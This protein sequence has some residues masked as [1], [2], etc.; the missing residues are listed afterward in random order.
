MA[1]FNVGETNLSVQEGEYLPFWRTVDNKNLLTKKEDC[2]IS[3]ENKILNDDTLK[4][5]FK[6]YNGSHLQSQDNP[7]S[8][9]IVL[10]CNRNTWDNNKLFD[11]ISSIGK[12]RW[13][14]KNAFG[15]YY[16]LLKKTTLDGVY[17]EYK[18]VLDHVDY[19]Y[20]DGSNWVDGLPVKRVCEVDFAVTK[21]YLEQKSSF[22]ITPKTITNGD[23]D[24]YLDIQGN[25]LI[26]KTDLDQIMVL[27]PQTYAGGNEVK[28][29]MAKFI[30][31]YEK[32]ALDTKKTIDGAKIYKVPGQNIL[33]FSGKNAITISQ[34][35][36][37]GSFATPFTIIVK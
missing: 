12:D 30:T 14:L 3:N 15:K 32:L 17:G 25:A 31:K 22:N 21:P 8:D 37:Y 23:L 4:C 1:C 28:T 7:I 29:M 27:N 9:E 20:C 19:K 2:S 33:V 36:D 11:Y 18:L 5:T 24:N 13:S 16:T 6:I 35:A 34:D 26:K 10:P